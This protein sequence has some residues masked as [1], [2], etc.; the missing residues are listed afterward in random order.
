[1][2]NPRFHQQT[3]DHDFDGMVLPLVEL[4]VVLQIHQLAID[5]C[6][7]VAV[8]QERLHL[9]LELALAPA[10]NRRHDHHA[11]FRSQGH[12]PLHD[13]VRRLSADGPA[14]LG[15]VW[16]PD[17]GEQQAKI[18]VDFGNGPDGRTRTA[19]GGLLLNRDGRAKSIDCINIRTFHLIQKLPR[20]GRKSLHVASLTL[21]VNRVKRQGRLPRPAQPGHHGQGVAR[22][23]DVNIF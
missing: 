10:D 1:M 2:L 17:G 16:N 15:A 5:A 14:A 12:D 6:A 4:K 20:V 8:F 7:G 9:F 21:G 19:A 18:I 3:I 22:N 23:L 11:V 13:L